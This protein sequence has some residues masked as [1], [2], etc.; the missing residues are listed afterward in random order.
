MSLDGWTAFQIGS[1]SGD[2]EVLQF[3]LNIHQDAWT[4]VRY[5]TTLLNL[6]GQTNIAIFTDALLKDISYLVIKT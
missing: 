4:N 5:N 6:A 2:L 3:I 1:R